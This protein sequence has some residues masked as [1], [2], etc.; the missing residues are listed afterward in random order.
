MVPERLHRDCNIRQTGALTTFL[1]QIL[2]RIKWSS[3]KIST[4]FIYASIF[5]A[6][7]IGLSVK[8]QN[9][10]SPTYS[11]YCCAIHPFISRPSDSY[12]ANNFVLTLIWLSNDKFKRF[13]WQVIKRN[14]LEILGFWHSVT[15]LA[16]SVKKRCWAW[17]VH[18]FC[19]V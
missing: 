3:V 5:S 10:N 2:K 16:N 9:N 7:T 11:S 17:H 12:I 8:I 6:R 13:A 4:K 1:H 19:N 15:I 18:K 14:S